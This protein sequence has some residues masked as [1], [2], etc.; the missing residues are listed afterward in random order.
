MKIR[1]YLMSL[2][3][4]LAVLVGGIVVAPAPAQAAVKWDLTGSYS[5]MAGSWAYGSW[6]WS[7]GRFYVEV[8][9]KDTVADG[10]AAGMCLRAEYSDGG[11]RKERVHNSGGKGTTKTV[12]YNFADNVSEIYGGEYVGGATTGCLA[13][14]IIY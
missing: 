10:E 7:G 11:S 3:T 8:N 6:W 4:G 2:A 13:V 9:V 5:D 1:R 14:G 12:T